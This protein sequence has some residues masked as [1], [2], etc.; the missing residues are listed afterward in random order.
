MSLTWPGLTITSN[1]RFTL[2][3]V[4]VTIPCESRI[5]QRYL[6]HIFFTILFQVHFG[7]RKM[8]SRWVGATLF[9]SVLVGIIVYALLFPFESTNKII[10]LPSRKEML[11]WFA[12]SQSADCEIYHEFGGVLN[13]M[14]K[15]SPALFF[16]DGQKSVC[17]DPVSL[18]PPADDCLVYSV[19][20][21]AEW[22]FDQAMESYGCEVFT[23]DPSMR[24]R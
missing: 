22:S 1:N 24:Y 10:R 8:S 9:C 21:N 14:Y 6:L 2:F 7:I 15:P 19:G 23:F 17:L 12:H 4:C 20:N 5:I 16:M 18:A 13:R 11:L 3:P